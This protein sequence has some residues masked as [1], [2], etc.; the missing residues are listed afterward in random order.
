M[1]PENDDREYPPRYPAHCGYFRC[2]INRLHPNHAAD[3]AW[4][5]AVHHGTL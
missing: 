1:R 4:L 5:A 2:S 3:D